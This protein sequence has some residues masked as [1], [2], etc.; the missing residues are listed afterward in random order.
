MDQFEVYWSESSQGTGRLVGIKA[1]RW[2]KQFGLS[3]GTR[4]APK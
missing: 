4:R 3:L 1:S 2:F